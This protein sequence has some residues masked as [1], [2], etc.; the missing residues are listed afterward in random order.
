MKKA[1]GLTWIGGI[2]GALSGIASGNQIQTM[3]SIILAIIGTEF[4]TQYRLGKFEGVVNELRTISES[5]KNM[6]DELKS[7]IERIEERLMK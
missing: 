5:V 4:I 6:I 7:R 2:I 1:L 3:W